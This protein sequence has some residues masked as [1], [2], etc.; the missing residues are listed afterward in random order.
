MVLYNASFLYV[1]TIL[2]PM[3]REIHKLDT[4]ASTLFYVLSGLSFLLTTPIAFY[5]RSHRIMKRR[6]IMYLALCMM[7][8][9]MIIRTGDFRDYL[10]ISYFF[11]S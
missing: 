11:P 2:N 3:L 9:G 8:L 7:G 5:L 1:T 6:M 4:E 10:L